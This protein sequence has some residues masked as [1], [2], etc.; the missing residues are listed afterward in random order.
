MPLAGTKII[1][2]TRLLPGPYC[3][4]LLA[5][6]GATVIKVEDKREG[7]YL[8][9]FPPQ[10]EGKNI[11]FE[12]L[13]RNKK[14]MTIDMKKKNGREI[15]L[16][17]VDHVDILVEGF[18]PDV[19]DRLGL[20]YRILKE[21]NPRLIYCAI[22]GYGQDSPYRE[23][24]G[25][26]I[27]YLALAGF[28]GLNT[29]P[30]GEPIV[31]GVQMADV[32]AGGLMAVIG[33]LAALNHQNQTGEGQF[34]DCSMFDGAMSLIPL[35]MSQALTL[36][37]EQKPYQDMLNG[38]LAS[39]NV[40]KTAEGRYMSLGS[41][42]AKFWKNFCNAVG[43]KDLIN[44]Y[45]SMGARGQKIKQEVSGIFKS[46]TKDEWITFFKDKD[47]CCEPVLTV[48]EAWSQ[49]LARA[50]HM[51][52]DSEP[53]RGFHY[54]QIGFPI[55]FSQNPSSLRSPAPAKAEHNEEILKEIGY[56]AKEIDNL[57]KQNII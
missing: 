44:E 22:T 17:L 9:S 27:N 34:V 36:G 4:R 2:M 20:G 3:T 16:R 54:A 46:K 8:R 19:M 42:E 45:N 6:M 33:I 24:A 11:Y 23:K 32:A 41:L 35:Q 40:Y 30:Q 13:N 51:C 48:K 1:D 12:A 57:K 10:M 53:S 18:R 31:P 5:D 26:D 25:H 29:T 47:C 15:I 43:R 52:V 55:K 38:G 50:R 14:G 7:D 56:S 39:Y 21:R 37:L 49:P 28:L